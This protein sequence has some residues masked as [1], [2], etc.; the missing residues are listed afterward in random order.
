MATRYLALLRGVNVGGNN[1]IPMAALRD[2]FAD[3][4]AAD[5]A[6][7]IQSGNV[8]FDGGRR[9]AAAWTTRIEAALS[10]RFGYAA[11]VV[12]RDR[13]ALRAVVAGAPAGFGTEPDRVRSDVLFLKGPSTAADVVAAMK[14]HEGVD[15]MAAGDGVVYFER[16]IERASQSALSKVVSLPVYREMTIRN[17]RTTTT[18]LSMLDERAG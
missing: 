2:C 6:T 13:D 18:L 14:P 3:L 10:E 7:Y 15:S 12:L 9:G 1:I 17:W 5:V 16:L 8:L 4:G 11:S